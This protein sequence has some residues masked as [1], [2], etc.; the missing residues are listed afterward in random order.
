MIFIRKKISWVLIST[1]LFLC[2]TVKIYADSGL[3]IDKLENS[4]IK[5]SHAEKIAEAGNEINE[6]INKY[7]NSDEYKRDLLKVNMEK[8]LGIKIKELKPITCEIT[9]YSSLASENGSYGMK[10]ASGEN[11]NS[12]TVANNF[13]DFGTDLYIEGHGYKVVEDTGSDRHFN[14][15]SRFDVY[16][17]RNDGESDSD[18]YKRVNMMGRD[19]ETGYIIV[20]D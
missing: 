16:V 1:F 4:E 14:R 8:E 13:L 19:T 2:V 18:Y 15:V 12:K 11:M 7:K 20:E 10:T 5:I 9:Y 6:E 3:E 17:P